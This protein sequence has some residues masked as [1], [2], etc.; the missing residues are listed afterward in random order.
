M[1]SSTNTCQFQLRRRRQAVALVAASLM[2]VGGALGQT[3]FYED[4]ESLTLGPSIDEGVPASNV[5]TKTPPAGWT[6][7]DSRFP[8][9]G[10]DQDGVTEWAG[11]GFANK[12]WWVNTAGG[13]RRQEF[14]FAT[15]N[16]MIADP[17]EW[18]DI[19]HAIGFWDASVTTGTIN[20]TA[21]PA[22]SLV[23]AFDSSWRPEGFDDGGANWPTG[24]E[25]QNINNQTGFIQASFNGGAFADALRWDS[26]SAG[27]FFKDHAPNESVVVPLNNPAGLNSL[28]LTIGMELGAN[29]WW[30]ALDNITV[31][32]PPLMIGLPAN[33]VS[34]TARIAEGL[35]KSVDESKPI[36]VML[37]GNTVTPITRERD[38]ERLNLVY[39]QSPQV[40]APKSSH[41]VKVSFTSN[42]GKL[43]EETRTFVAPSYTQASAT[44]FAVTAILT[45]GGPE[46]DRWL[47]IDETKPITVKLN[48]TSVTPSAP[49]RNGTQVSLTYSQAPN[50]F[51]SGSSN[52]LE[53][54]FQT[55]GGATVVDT[56]TFTA[57]TWTS[58]PGSLATALGT[59]SGAG[60]RFRTYQLETARPS[61]TIASA[62]AQLRGELGPS[63][64]DSFGEVNGAF[65]V[66]FVNFEQGGGAAGNFTLDAPEPQTVPDDYIPGIPFGAPN[67]NIAADIRTFIEFPTAGV[68]TMVVNSDDGFQ[69]STGTTNA[70]TH[71]ILSGYDGGRGA[72]DTSTYFRIEQPGVYFFR[73]LWFEGGG[74][75]SVEWFTVNPNGSR[76][77]VGGTQTGSLKAFKTR[78]VAEP[79][80]TAAGIQSFAWQDGKLVITYS[81][82]LKS[83]GSVNGAYSNVTGATSPFTVTP[84]G[85][86]QFYTAQ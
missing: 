72:S 32:T 36:T 29:D 41:T 18:D 58:V 52:T 71:L 11:W 43:I 17:D 16:V 80:L 34:F 50:V 47:T 62:E 74:G 22:N 46:E 39:S 70:P 38:G 27:S 48:G 23:L 84:D 3:A 73:L 14:T 42:E 77:L 68:Y 60:I 44:P 4:F 54:T 75:A 81:G 26:D 56:V 28:K 12:D 13:Q 51:P 24:P 64:H 7:D 83:A 40:W 76:A 9:A 66:S 2:A 6:R 45:D 59:G 1:K 78:T 33:G 53:V 8:G 63:V 69:L 15:G 61:D 19:G 30:W 57:P 31:G 5:F 37:D 25:G 49:V 21:A 67:D 79:P 20:F 86:Q 65:E 35:G 82:T 85:T 55:T 10:T